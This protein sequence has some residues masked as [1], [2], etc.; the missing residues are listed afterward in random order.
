MNDS[1]V[2]TSGIIDHNPNLEDKFSC[3]ISNWL[4]NGKDE[5][6]I[7]LYNAYEPYNVDQNDQ[8][9]EIEYVLH[10][11]KL[12]FDFMW[13]SKDDYRQGLVFEEKYYL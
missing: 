9:W 7:R 3:N 8:H 4:T 11:G 6:I 13:D 2:F 5:V 12:E 1:L 10:K